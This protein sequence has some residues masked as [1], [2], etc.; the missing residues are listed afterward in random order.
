MITVQTRER[1]GAFRIPVGSYAGR[2][3]EQDAEH[4]GADIGESR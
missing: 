1:H 3:G 4:L 2:E